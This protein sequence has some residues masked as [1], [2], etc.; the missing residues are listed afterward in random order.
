MAALALAN[1]RYWGGV[2]GQVNEQ[3]RHWEARA[4]A[5]GDPKARQLALGKLREEGFNAQAAA[6]TATRAPRAHRA[7]A[8]RAIVAL[9][10]LFDYLDGAT[11][12]PHE[13]PLGE[14]ERLYE[15]FL[16]AVDPERELVTE[17]YLGELAS[18]VRAAV[19][20]LPARA[21]IAASARAAS[22]RAAQAQ[23]R[24]HAVPY[25]GG[26]QAAAWARERA[27]GSGLGW[28]EYL[29]SAAASVVTLHALIAA[30][31][32]PGTSPAGAALIDETYLRVCAVVTLMDTIVDERGDSEAGGFGYIEFYED[33]ALLA[34]TLAEVAAQA[35]DMAGALPRGAHH[36]MTLAGIVAYW[37]TAQGARERQAAATLAPMQREL[38]TL[39]GPPM[40]VMRAWRAAKRADA[41]RSEPPREVERA[42]SC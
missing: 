22:T 40:L 20:T 29:A 18:T 41:R 15:P 33:R 16:A 37:S 38:R 17:G 39:I 25:L 27:G 31:A 21:A 24:A 35:R 5:I 14:G 13:D 30:A 36:L 9:E 12:R 28:R 3:L 7:A 34:L 42:M 26:A 1:A 32:D 23:V 8:V 10:L 6:V 11:E 4:R 19:A 2:A